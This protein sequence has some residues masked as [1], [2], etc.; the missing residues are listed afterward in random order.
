[1]TALSHSQYSPMPSEIH[2]HSLQ[3]KK[4]HKKERDQD[5]DITSILLQ[6]I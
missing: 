3:K 1:M 2:V 6:Q 5:Y 4:L